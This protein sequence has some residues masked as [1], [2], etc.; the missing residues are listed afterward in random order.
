MAEAL[1]IDPTELS[2]EPLLQAALDHGLEEGS[3]IEARDLQEMLQATWALLSVEQRFSSNR[4]PRRGRKY[5]KLSIFYTG[6][7]GGPQ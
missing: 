2:V 3:D 1:M 7:A 6:A 4:R 5:L